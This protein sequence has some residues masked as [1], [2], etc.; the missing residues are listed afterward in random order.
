[1]I[2]P[3]PHRLYIFTTCAVVLA[4]TCVRV[5]VFMCCVSVRETRESVCVRE[6]TSERETECECVREREKEKERERECVCVCARER[7]RVSA[8]S[9]KACC[10]VNLT[11]LKYQAGPSPGTPRA[12]LKMCV[13]FCMCVN[14]Y[15]N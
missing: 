4:H 15:L 9:E 14:V 2:S 10:R 5:C 12:I 11:I 7:E 13:C 1:M 6:R 8:S 3:L